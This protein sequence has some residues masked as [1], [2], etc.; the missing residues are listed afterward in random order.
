MVVEDLR[1]TAACG[2]CRCCADHSEPGPVYAGRLT[3]PG[4]CDWVAAEESRG[5]GVLRP[6][7]AQPHVPVRMIALGD[8]DDPGMNGMHIRER[9]ELLKTMSIP[10]WGF[11]N[12]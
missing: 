12:G 1:A 2:P 9:K 8:V 10:G 3:W 7:P 11:E 5:E 6:H 4:C